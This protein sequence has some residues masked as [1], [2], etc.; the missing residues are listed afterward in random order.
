MMSKGSRWNSSESTRLD[1]LLEF[2]ERLVV[3]LVDVDEASEVEEDE[4]LEVVEDEEL[5]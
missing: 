1:R 5:E 4:G 3:Q 2:E